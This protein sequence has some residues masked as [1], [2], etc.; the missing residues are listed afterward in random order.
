[1]PLSTAMQSI[2]VKDIPY[3]ADSAELFNRLRDLPEAIWLDSG[4][5]RSLQGC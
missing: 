1:M 4:K 2:R 3:Q 5:P